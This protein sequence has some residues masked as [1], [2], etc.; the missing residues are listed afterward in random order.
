MD[1]VFE[2][3]SRFET[4]FIGYWRIE[5]SF[6]FTWHYHPEYELV[7]IVQDEGER[8]VA[9]SIESYVSGDL[10]LLGPNLPHTWSSRK[11]GNAK[12]NS[13]AVVLQFGQD[14]LGA[15][16]FAAPEFERI[17]ELLGAAG[18]GLQFYGK[19]QQAAL[20]L[21]LTMFKGDEQQRL[22]CLLQLL[23]LLSR[24]PERREISVRK[25]R[26]TPDA[27]ER[28]IIDRVFQFT[29]DHYRHPIK[30]AEM[31]RMANMSES[32]FSRF[33]RK[34]TGKS[35]VQFLIE[36]RIAMACKL[37]IESEKSVI[38]ICHECG[39]QNLSNFNRQFLKLKA[40]SP[41]DYRKKWHG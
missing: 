17:R 39:F 5:P 13:R 33:F 41:R 34:F 14:F 1:P 19:T 15:G 22:L 31:A 32:T 3:L 20:R 4:S 25:T 23:D 37:L 9:D 8:F 12:G 27:K 28:K 36:M 30:N 26:E 6:P 29:V 10:V 35:F 24:S 16:F 21:M 2:K 7:A 38:D 18:G 40:C 11:T